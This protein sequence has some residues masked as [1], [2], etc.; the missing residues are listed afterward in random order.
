[1]KMKMMVTMAVGMA[2]VMASNIHG[3][4]A[5]DGSGTVPGASS[6]QS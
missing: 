5:Y 4:S 1:M 3:R 2:A 6:I